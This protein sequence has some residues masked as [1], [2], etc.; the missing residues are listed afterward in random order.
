MAPLETS[1]AVGLAAR[2]RSRA[3][4]NCSP[5]APVASVSP[6]VKKSTDFPGFKGIV[7]LW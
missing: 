2:S 4:P 6:S 5:R 1:T 3:I 7:T